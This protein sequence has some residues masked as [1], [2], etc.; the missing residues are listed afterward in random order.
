MLVANYHT[1]THLCRHADGTCLDYARQAEKDGCLELGFSDHC[2]YPNDSKDNWQYCR[3]DFSELGKYKAEVESARQAVKF[4]V[5]F[6]F[7]CEWD[8]DYRSWYEDVLLGEAGAEYLVFGPH[9]FTEGNSHLYIK[10]YFT[11]ANLNK[12][13]D[14]MI[15][16]MNS[17]LYAFVA[18]PDLFMASGCEWNEQTKACSK[19]ILTAAKELNLPVEINGYGIVK[20]KVFNAQ[21]ERFPYPVKEFWELAKDLGNTIICNSDAHSP[22]V[23]IKN[24]LGARAFAQ[25]LGI[26][27]TDFIK[28]DKN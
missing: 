18:H 5:R 12:Y 28:L 25:E 11:D 22:E 23:V 14:Q 9:W 17:G 7:E 2:P 20:Q 26:T 24:N 19:A 8:A 21:G 3:M 16:G 1:H 15:V 13:I 10:E 4:P 6:G 27:L